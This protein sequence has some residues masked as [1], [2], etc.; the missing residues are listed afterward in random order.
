M[1]ANVD[2]VK[3]IGDSPDSIEALRDAISNDTRFQDTKDTY[4][5]TINSVL[6]QSNV[7]VEMLR[8]AAK[9]KLAQQ[10]QFKNETKV[11]LTKERIEKI[12]G[13]ILDIPSRHPYKHEYM[14]RYKDILRGSLAKVQVL[15][16]ADDDSLIQYIRERSM[17]S[18]ITP[19]TPFGLSVSD[20]L[21]AASM[22]GALNARHTAGKR[23][24]AS[25][26]IK[27]QR[28]II[29]LS[30]RKY[31]TVMV[32]FKERQTFKSIM[33]EWRARLVG[34]R[35]IDLI[36]SNDD[37]SVEL[38]T[39]IPTWY[40]TFI[41]TYKLDMEEYPHT[42]KLVIKLN[43]DKLFIYKV[44]LRSLKDKLEDLMHNKARDQYTILF[45]SPLSN[46]VE[47]HIIPNDKHVSDTMEELKSEYL[48]EEWKED[49]LNTTISGIQGVRNILP[50][51]RKVLDGVKEVINNGVST[52]TV[53]NIQY[54]Y[55]GITSNHLRDLLV[56]SDIRRKDITIL[57]EYSLEVNINV[58]DPVKWIQSRVASDSPIPAYNLK[59]QSGSWVLTLVNSVDT[60]SFVELLNSI[61]E[62]KFTTTGDSITITPPRISILKEVRTLL[63][64]EIEA[65]IQREETIRTDRNKNGTNISLI[66][67]LSKIEDKSEIY[68][69]ELSGGSFEQIL[70]TEGIDI[71]RSYSNN[72]KEMNSILG[73]EACRKFLTLE[74]DETWSNGGT[75]LQ[76]HSIT[77]TADS[78][79]YRGTL[80]PS[81]HNG[82]TSN[83]I[84][85]L[86]KATVHA[87]TKW[88]TQAGLNNERD[89]L[90]SS[91]AC[92][93]VGK[94]IKQ[95][96]G[97][98][99]IKQEEDWEKQQEDD[100]FDDLLMEDEYIGAIDDSDS[101][102][103]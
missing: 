87:A 99:L 20:D 86:S 69:A 82:I 7:E 40:Q 102:E 92:L 93:M 27:A 42:R 52:L 85:F 53:S 55:Y 12:I 34:I 73:I 44:N 19:G 45:N 4:K 58:F 68:F 39:N 95:G 61:A 32:A 25:G 11:F 67:P 79:C 36:S 51:P 13:G 84:G 9:A 50:V 35:L 43:K 65:R 63:S 3:L 81:S 56:A 6:E 64:R 48:L 41:R 98:V 14:A 57:D 83:P 1:E 62:L 37:I 71:N 89:R 24:N 94:K 2:Q 77:T 10:K 49:L 21:G 100:Q 38:S 15:E 8:N 26:G 96:T 31:P 60:K 33:S 75:P 30:S 5:Q 29:L 17:R 97:I 88:L 78:M 101:G 66:T 28:E 74:I 103:E 23:Q 80:T 91:S 59:Q 54:Q 18:W 46:I 76:P 47:L 70:H 16:N 22:Q 90:Q 72:P